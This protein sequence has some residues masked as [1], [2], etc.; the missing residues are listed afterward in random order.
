VVPTSGVFTITVRL[1]SEFTWETADALRVILKIDYGAGY[2]Y[3]YSGELLLRK[4]RF[5]ASPHGYSEVVIKRFP[6]HIGSDYGRVSLCMMPM[7]FAE[8]VGLYSTVNGIA[9]FGRILVTVRRIK[10]RLLMTPVRSRCTARHAT[11]GP[12]SPTLA[13]RYH[14]THYVRY[15]VVTRPIPLFKSVEYSTRSDYGHEV[16]PISSYAT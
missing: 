10:L 9:A 4:R 13:E 3:G 2:A 15:V 16:E 14:L 11:P 5:K 1:A 12:L 8:F 7:P 6:C